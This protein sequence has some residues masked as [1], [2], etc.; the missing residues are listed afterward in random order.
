MERNTASYEARSVV[1]NGLTGNPTFSLLFQGG[2][3]MPKALKELE[4]LCNA[5]KRKGTDELQF[6]SAH[7]VHDLYLR[8]T[9]EHE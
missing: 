3:N 9:L 5:D 1:G 6:I 7:M 2:D 4:E 8:W